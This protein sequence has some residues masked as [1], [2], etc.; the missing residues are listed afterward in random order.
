MQAKKA[1]EPQ[2]FYRERKASDD[3]TPEV[4]S[5]ALLELPDG[6]VQ[7]Y[8]YGG[9]RE[10]SR[11]TAI[12]RSRL[13]SGGADAQWQ[14]SEV[15]M[16]LATTQEALDRF[17][18]K[19]GNPV[20]GL[21]QQGRVWLFYVSVSV[22]G[23]AGSAINVAISD[24]NGEQWQRI[25]RL[26]TS[27]FFN[28][29]TLVKGTPLQYQDG[30]FLVPVYHEFI[31]KFSELIHVSP[32]AEVIDKLRLTWGDHSLQPVVLPL[33]ETEATTVMR[34]A[35]DPPKRILVSHTDDGGA[36][37]SPAQP[38]DLPNPDAAVAG[39]R[40]LDGNLLMV[41]NNSEHDRDVLSL[42]I[43]EDGG[44]HWRVIHDF[45]NGQG[46]EGDHRYSYPYF[47]RTS[48]GHYHLAYTWNREYIKHIEFNHAWLEAQQ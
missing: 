12:Y 6:S 7:A 15:V 41:F 13:I 9:T 5:A 28:I 45:E 16:D 31:G 29:S 19:L 20:V 24:S 46:Q 14:P 32:E 48:Q 34:Y 37:W 26:I 17:I 23:W 44:D 47:I 11:D 21:D 35:G 40:S 39:A 8:W 43:S 33:T 25:E 2:P 3:V 38:L 1:S 36:H 10:G 30:S 42:A 4:H 22:G 27:P 18:K